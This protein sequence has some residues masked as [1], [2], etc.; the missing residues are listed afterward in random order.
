MKYTKAQV[1]IQAKHYLEK[2]EK[3]INE[4][5]VKHGKIPLSELKM[6]RQKENS[7]FI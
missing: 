6:K 4:D 7:H 3:E 2:L 1:D 5:R